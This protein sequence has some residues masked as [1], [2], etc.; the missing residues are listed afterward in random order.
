MSGNLDDDPELERHSRLHYRVGILGFHL[1]RPS[2]EWAFTIIRR[3]G[4]PLRSNAGYTVLGPTSLD[5]IEA[6][7]EARADCPPHDDYLKGFE[8]IDIGPLLQR[9][10]RQAAPK[11]AQRKGKRR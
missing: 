11:R 3:V 5:D 8:S 6:W 2:W 10:A 4:T 9:F 7:V 1:E